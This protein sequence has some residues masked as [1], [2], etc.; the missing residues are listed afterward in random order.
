MKNRIP[1]ESGK[2][3]TYVIRDQK[4]MLDRDLAQLY[5]VSMDVF[6]TRV[7]RHIE[8]FP[9]DFMFQLTED[10]VEYLK[11][12]EPAL[13]QLDLSEK[14][15]VFAEGGLLMLSSVLKSERAAQLSVGIIRA[16]FR[17]HNENNRL[18]EV[19]IDPCR[20]E[21]GDRWGLM[22]EFQSC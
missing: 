19:Y 13:N 14:P 2:H 12:Q 7:K 11:R 4:V 3:R 22:P 5:G 1:Q 20:L 17:N 16:L 9:E 8:R 15:C 18:W 21:L 10:E 6:N